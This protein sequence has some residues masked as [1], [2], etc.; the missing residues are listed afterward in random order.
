MNF[1]MFYN[2]KTLLSVQGGLLMS[3]FELYILASAMC[4]EAT[5]RCLRN[6]M[7]A[8]TLCNR[9]AVLTEVKSY[10]FL[11]TSDLPF[12]GTFQLPFRAGLAPV[13]AAV[14]AYETP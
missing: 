13:T 8:E 10:L 4:E 12:G 7:A 6:E 11:A 14:F 5:P 9:L 2:E 3:G 1:A